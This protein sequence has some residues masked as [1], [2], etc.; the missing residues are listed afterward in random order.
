MTDIQIVLN[1]NILFLF[2]KLF[3]KKK[4]LFSMNTNDCYK[5]QRL[6]LFIYDLDMHGPIL[7]F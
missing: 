7:I 3:S 2:V 4:T 5:R 6:Y 1:G